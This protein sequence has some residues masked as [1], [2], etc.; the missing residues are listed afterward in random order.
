MDL[1]YLMD[2]ILSIF[3]PTAQ[4]G[5]QYS[6][7]FLQ[8]GSFG[9]FFYYKCQ[10]FCPDVFPPYVKLILSFLYNLLGLALPSNILLNLIYV[11][12]LNMLVFYM[13]YLP[14]FIPQ[15]R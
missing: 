3:Y 7:C 13:D 4:I 9:C 10:Y 5:K 15:T 1:E 6:L 11:N 14:M 8:N 12:M 2:S